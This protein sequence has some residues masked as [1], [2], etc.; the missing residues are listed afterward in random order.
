MAV[1]GLDGDLLPLHSSNTNEVVSLLHL[2]GVRDVLLGWPASLSPSTVDRLLP[3]VLLDRH[4]GVLH[5]L[6]A[7]VDVRA[8]LQSMARTDRHRRHCLAVGVRSTGESAECGV[9]ASGRGP[10]SDGF[11]LSDLSHRRGH[12][13]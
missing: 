6:S 4:H 2:P 3:L 1:S 9:I 11:L 7:P 12:R 10:I 8:P 13:C 5:T